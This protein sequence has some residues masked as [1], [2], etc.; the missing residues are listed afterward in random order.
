[1]LRLLA[2]REQGYDD[3]AALM[4]LSVA[5]V[6]AK[7][8]GALAQLEAEGEPRPDVPPPFPM[9][10]EEGGTTARETTPASEAPEA[11]GPEPASEESAPARPKVAAD[12][13]KVPP[14]EPR[15]EPA[16][17]KPEPSSPKVESG[18]KTTLATA[19]TGGSSGG[20]GRTITIPSGRGLWPWIGGAVAIIAIVVV[21]VL[22]VG[23][24][25][26]SS[27]TE[28]STTA[29]VSN[30]A[31]PEPGES[32]PEEVPTTESAN[33]KDPTQAVLKPVAGEKGGGTAI[34]LKAKV[35]GKERLVL[36]VVANGLEPTGKGEVYAVCLAQSSKRVLPVASTVVK[37]DGKVES[38]VIVPTEVLAFVASGVFDKI[39]LTRADNARLGTALKVAAEE[40]KAPDYT[41]EPVLI[42][43]VTGPLVGAAVREEETQEAEE[44]EG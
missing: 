43:S 11:K 8:V 29:Q 40:G 34:F 5:E 18:P 19:S 12:P 38:E 9:A 33:L 30:E 4:G 14:S 31:E 39:Y 24:G 36:G 3:I 7:V 42:G 26:D 10:G 6:R 17:A 16:P 2:Q 44:K 37:A 32:E 28:T 27:S 13:P 15:S 21:V 22:I 1:M 25:G 23:G 35:K 20:G 41:G